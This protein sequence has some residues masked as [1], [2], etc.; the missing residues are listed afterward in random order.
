MACR[1]PCNKADFE[2][3]KRQRSLSVSQLTDEN[4]KL[5]KEIFINRY[6]F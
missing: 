4:K 5:E 6:I 3:T 1:P 2:V